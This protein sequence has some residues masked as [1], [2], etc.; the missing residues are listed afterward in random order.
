MNFL[1]ASPESSTSSPFLAY[2]TLSAAKKKWHH[3]RDYFQSPWPNIRE[4]NVFSWLSL[5]QLERSNRTPECFSSRMCFE[6]GGLW[7]GLC[8]GRR[9]IQV[10]QVA[11]GMEIFGVA[12]HVPCSGRNF[13]SPASLQQQNHLVRGRREEESGIWTQTDRNKD[14]N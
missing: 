12:M 8:I 3:W 11:A 6:W 7:G 1:W 10:P 2:L 4:T 14:E 9:K 5:Q 13:G